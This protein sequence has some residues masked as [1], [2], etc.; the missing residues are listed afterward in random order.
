MQ[1]LI[2]SSYLLTHAS[3]AVL[4]KARYKLL[5]PLRDHSGRYSPPQPQGGS[6]GV[7]TRTGRAPLRTKN[8]SCTRS[9]FLSIPMHC[10]APLRLHDT[11]ASQHAIRAPDN[12]QHESP[13]GELYR[14]S[15]HASSTLHSYRYLP[16][17]PALEIPLLS[18]LSVQHRPKRTTNR[19]QPPYPVDTRRQSTRLRRSLVKTLRNN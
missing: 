16:R 1:R 14:I 13:A 5:G 9:L 11:P 8:N 12:T 3:K 2:C 18:S 4:E 15:S 19:L 6:L 7:S 17:R 10:C